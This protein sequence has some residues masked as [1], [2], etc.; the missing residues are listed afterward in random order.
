MSWCEIAGTILLLRHKRAE[1]GKISRYNQ[2]GIQVMLR[3]TAALIRFAMKN[4]FVFLFAILLGVPLLVAQDDT[5]V[6]EIIARINNNIITRADLR[7]AREQ[8][9]TEM[10]QQEPNATSAQEKDR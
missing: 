3:T 4:F 1:R 8:L 9:L 5:V 2:D 10:H 6:E 7:R